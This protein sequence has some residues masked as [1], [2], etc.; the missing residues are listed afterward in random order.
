MSEGERLA[1]LET[2]LDEH[3]KSNNERFDRLFGM[4]DDFI[5]TANEKFASKYVED[6]VKKLDERFAS[7]LVERIVYGMCGAILMA[8]LYLALNHLGIKK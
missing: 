4:M 2:K 5:G 3:E 7:K 8:V 1:R 6:Q